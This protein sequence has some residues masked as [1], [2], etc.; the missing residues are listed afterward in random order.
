MSGDII[1]LEE[2][3]RPQPSELRDPA[4]RVVCSQAAYCDP[5]LISEVIVPLLSMQQ[6]CLLCIS[7][8]LESGNH[9]SRMFELKDP[10]GEP[11][12][13]TIQISL[14][15]DD[16]LKT[17]HPELCTHKL[18]EMPR[19]LSSAKMEVVKSLLSDDPA[20]LL[21][22]SMGVGADS[23]NKAFHAADINALLKRAGMGIYRD[24]IE[25]NDRDN[26]NHVVVAVDPAGGGASAFAVA[27]VC[28]QPNGSIVVRAYSL[29]HG[30]FPSR[31]PRH[32]SLSTTHAVTYASGLWHECRR[33]RGVT[34]G[35]TRR[36]MS[37]EKES[38]SPGWTTRSC[39][40]KCLSSSGSLLSA[41]STAARL[42]ATS[43]LPSG[44]TAM[45]L[46]SA[47]ACLAAAL[48]PYTAS[49]NGHSPPT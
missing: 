23:T 39:A 15:C 11:L 16:C 43:S 34:K 6:S 41:N 9:Y 29:L 14:V 27:S 7:T 24:A 30:Q 20:M 8:L 36:A 33:K 45:L 40:E 49:T 22:E 21:R 12:F 38:S 18:A 4:D 2:V 35:S 1:V 19:W 10:L 13:E 42:H 17:D 47:A 28:Q 46:S 32:I 48:C 3:R 31:S 5:G 25:Y 37:S 26:T 44:S